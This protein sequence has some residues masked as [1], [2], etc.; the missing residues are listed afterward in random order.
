MEFLLQCRDAVM[1][2]SLAD[3]SNAY[4]LLDRTL[5]RR[6][7]KDTGPRARVLVRSMACIS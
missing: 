7:G 6:I 3:P 1:P 5:P 4:G 2:P